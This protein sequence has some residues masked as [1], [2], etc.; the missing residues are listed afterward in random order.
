M[1]QARGLDREFV[2]GGVA[3]YA[4]ALELYAESRPQAP[5]AASEP[6]DV[7]FDDLVDKAAADVVPARGEPGLDDDF[8]DDDPEAPADDPLPGKKKALTP[9]NALDTLRSAMRR[10]GV[11]PGVQR[12]ALTL[13]DDRDRFRIEA[14]FASPLSSDVCVALNAATAGRPYEIRLGESGLIVAFDVDA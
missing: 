2:D 8:N 4:A 10:V 9:G 7:T 14:H 6:E 1:T 3:G 12:V 5:H 11:V 13:P